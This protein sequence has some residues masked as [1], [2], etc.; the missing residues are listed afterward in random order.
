[1][2]EIIS[3]TALA[4]SVIAALGS[5]VKETHIQK[6]KGL[7]FESDCRKNGTPINSAAQSIREQPLSTPPIFVPDSRPTLTINETHAYDHYKTFKVSN[8]INI[9]NEVSNLA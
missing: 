3:I 6:C 7:C 1:M 5:F 8:P 4:V 2:T 9:I